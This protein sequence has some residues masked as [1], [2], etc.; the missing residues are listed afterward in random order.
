MPERISIPYH[1]TAEAGAE[2]NVTIYTVPAARTLRSIEVSIAFPVGQYGELEISFY[3]GIMRVLP[4]Q[5]AYTGDNML[6]P[7]RAFAEW[8]TG[9][10]V[11]VH[12][13]NTNSTEVREAYILVEGELIQPGE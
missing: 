9:E 3:R 2:G 12:Y 10:S 13:K 8:G 1:L 6:F 11:K 7:T 4:T 5:G